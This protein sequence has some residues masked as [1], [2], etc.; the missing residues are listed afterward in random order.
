MEKQLSMEFLKNLFNDRQ[1]SYDELLKAV[2]AH[3]KADKDN[4]IKIANLAGGEY[5]SK[6][7]YDAKEKELTKANDQITV[8]N[9]T[10]NSFDGE[11]KD[12]DKKIKDLQKQYDTDTKALKNDFAK[13]TAVNRFFSEHKSKHEGLLRKE[14]DLDKLSVDDNGNV[15]GL[16]EQG[17]TI[18]ESYADLFETSLGGTPPANPDGAGTPPK[19]PGKM[20]YE[21]FVAMEENK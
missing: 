1:L 15:L 18:L 5:I 21:D 9:N 11:K 10:V 4:Q 6:E 16:E 14:F 13:Q 19:D 20:T 3:N 12:L 8:L 2:E 17:K 7:K